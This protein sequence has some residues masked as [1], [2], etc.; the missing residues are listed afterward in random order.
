MG[1]GAVGKFMIVGQ[2]PGRDEDLTGV[3]FQGVGGQY[4]ADALK[5][6]SIPWTSCFFDN[7]L[8][9]K[10][11]KPIKEYLDPC[12]ARLE[13]VIRLAQ[14]RL[15][16]AAGAVASKWLSGTRKSMDSLACTTQE[17]QGTP[18]FFVTHPMEP[19]RLIDQPDAHEKSIVKIRREFQALGAHAREMGLLPHDEE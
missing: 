3:P 7:C 2:A 19:G 6:A 13:D 10:C 15:I 17:W 4:T 9:C 16:I 11:A 12:R 1:G 18:V 8:A 14:P 5:I